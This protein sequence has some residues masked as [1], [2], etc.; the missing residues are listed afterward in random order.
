M[1]DVKRLLAALRPSRYCNCGKGPAESKPLLINMGTQCWLPVYKLT[2][3]SFVSKIL[4]AA[5]TVWT[6]W[7]QIW[8]QWRLLIEETNSNFLDSFVL[9]RER[10]WNWND[11]KMT[12]IS[13]TKQDVNHSIT[14][15]CVTSV[16]AGFYLNLCLSVYLVFRMLSWQIT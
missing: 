1:A 15:L 7:L 16:I 3:E 14:M 12:A 6:D 11:L 5:Y 8:D 4:K 2:M 9:S 13:N 10:S